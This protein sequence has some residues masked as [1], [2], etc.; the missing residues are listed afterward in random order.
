M[1]AAIAGFFTGFSLILAIGAQNAFVLR[2][3]LLRNHVFPLVLFCALSDALLI[4]AGVL[5][6]G[7]LVS[8]VPMLPVLMAVMGA[9]FLMAY[10]AL[11][12]VAAL[13]G[14]YEMDLTGRARSLKATLAIAAAFTWLNPHVYLD[15]LGLIGAIST[16]F[17]DW[18]AR[19]LF[20]LGAVSASFVFFFSLGYGA[21]LLAPTMT[22][23]SSWRVLDIGI[24]LTMWMIAVGLVHGVWSGSIS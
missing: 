17:D 18:N 8:A 24:G 5:G 1:T 23:P 15:T 22:R 20:G 13:K 9:V 11:R 16:S 10:G 21:R 7:V 4:I 12:F 19:I 14:Q 3:G 6:F 2:Q